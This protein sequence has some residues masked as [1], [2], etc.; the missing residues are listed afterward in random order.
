VTRNQSCKVQTQTSLE[1][2]NSWGKGK[3]AKMKMR[4]GRLAPRR[5]HP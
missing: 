2:W 5:A 1:A 3:I 4:C